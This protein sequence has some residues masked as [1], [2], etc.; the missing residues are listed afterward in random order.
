[1]KNNISLYQLYITTI[2]CIT[3]IQNIV[4][5]QQIEG[6]ITSLQNIIK[7]IEKEQ[8][9]P[10]EINS[11]AIQEDLN[12]N[13]KA[14]I[15]Q[16]QQLDA[17]V[18]TL[19]M[20]QQK[21]L[22]NKQLAILEPAKPTLKTAIN[23]YVV[24]TWQK[25]GKGIAQAS[26]DAVLAGVSTAAINLVT[27]GIKMGTGNLINIDTNTLLIAGL[28]ST[29]AAALVA[30][31]KNR[32]ASSLSASAFSESLIAPC[33]I[34]NAYTITMP[35]VTGPITYWLTSEAIATAQ[36]IADQSGIN[37]MLGNIDINK[38][39]LPSW[40]NQAGASNAIVEAAL[41]TVQSIVR[42]QKIASVLTE[43]G[44]IVMQ[45]AAVG[46][47][48]HMAGFGYANTSLIPSVSNA[49]LTG[50]A[51]GM[52]S[53]TLT[54]A[55]KISPGALANIAT[56]GVVQKALAIGGGNSQA[57]ATA[58]VQ[59]T[60]KEVSNL[61]LDESKKQGGL[62]Q[63]LNKGKELL[64]QTIRSRWGSTWAAITDAWATIQSIEPIPL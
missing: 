28:T 34:G 53:A 21:E 14:L 64:G 6:K 19:P 55:G 13:V 40:S 27:Q 57:S 42:N 17:S 46:G 8:P 48:M 26:V 16:A 32:G 1:M 23:N 63:T 47:L 20:Q 51:Q 24:S 58:V 37:K 15:Q 59:A 3:P 36:T 45:S 44:W 12:K 56:A 54:V 39:L 10:N 62:L 2:L 60:I 7:T 35:S 30:L 50:L 33:M 9:K 5:M 43:V 25:Y 29:T 52:V 61:F 31:T 41:P 18:A 38:T 22:N 11:P 4:S 49:V